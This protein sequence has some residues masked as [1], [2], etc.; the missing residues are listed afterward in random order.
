VFL[1][2]GMAISRRMRWAGHVTW[3]RSAYKL[4][5]GKSVEKGQLIRHGCKMENNI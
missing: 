2:D 5:G 1:P 4:L 3:E